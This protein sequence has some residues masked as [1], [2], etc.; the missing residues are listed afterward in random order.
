MARQ[1]RNIFLSINPYINAGLEIDA[2]QMEAISASLSV[3]GDLDPDFSVESDKSSDESGN[4]TKA[5]SKSTQSST[6]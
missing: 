3:D 4:S 1:Q 6:C 2:S 5:R